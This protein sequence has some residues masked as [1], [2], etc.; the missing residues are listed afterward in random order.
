MTR[1]RVPF[2][3][4]GPF[5]HRKRWRLDIFRDGERTKQSYGTYAEALQAAFEITT[6]VETTV[7]TPHASP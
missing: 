4:H 3:V 7:E 6:G 5:Q 1:E 2:R